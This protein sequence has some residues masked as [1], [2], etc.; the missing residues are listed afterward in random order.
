MCAVVLSRE[1]RRS[2]QG[3]TPDP[4]PVPSHIDLS[5]DDVDA[6]VDRCRD[7]MSH[8]MSDLCLTG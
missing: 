6:F 1:C 7:L 5:V 3:L 4:S 8:I 2:L